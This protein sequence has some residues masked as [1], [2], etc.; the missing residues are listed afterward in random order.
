MQDP[1]AAS[2]PGRTRGGAPTFTELSR[3]RQ[4][5]DCSIA[6]LG[7]QG[8]S[9]TTLSRVADRAGVSKGVVSYHFTSK[10]DLLEATV[11]DVFARGREYAE[12]EWFAHLDDS[13]TPADLLR[14]YLESNLAYIAAHPDQIAAAIEIIRNHRGADGSLIFGPPWS[15]SLREPLEEIFKAGQ[16]EGL[17]RPFAPGVMATAVRRVIDGFSFEVLGTA[18]LDTA[19]YTAEIVEL[20]D[21]ATRAAP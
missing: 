3:R 8:Y 6:V 11:H 16:H 9:G 13:A 4:L 10:S 12:T 15:G 2:E 1:R 19:A 7:E 18:E 17:F 20:F 14:T 21:R 5:V